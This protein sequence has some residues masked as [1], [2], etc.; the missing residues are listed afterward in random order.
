MTVYGP[1]GGLVGSTFNAN[2]ADAWLGLTITNAGTYTVVLQSYR[3][4]GD[5]GTYTLH[6]A[7]T[8]GAFIVPAGDEGGAMTSGGNYSGT[9][10]IGDLDLWSFSASAGDQVILRIGTIGVYPEMTVYG[11][12]GGLVGSTFNANYADAWLGLTIT[13]TGTYTVVLQSYRVT[14]DSGTY[15]LHFAET[16]GAFIVPVH[17]EGGPLANGVTHFATNSVGDLDMWSFVG[18]PGDSNILQIVGTS[19]YPQMDLYGPDGVLVKSVGNGALSSTLTYVVTNAG[20]YTVLVQSYYVNGDSGTY[21]LRYSRVP[22]DLIVPDTQVL[23]EGSTLNVSISAQDPDLPIKALTFAK[24]SAPPGVVLTLT[25][26]T[27]ATITWPTDETTGP[28]TNTIVVT[29]TDNVGGKNFTRTNSFIVIVNELNEPPVLT[30]PNQQ[31]IDE[32]TPLNVSASATDP[33]IPANP[34]T[35]SLVSPPTGMTIDPNTGAIA[36]TP[37]EAQGPVT[38]TVTVVVMDTNPPAV[39]TT[40]IS[41]TNSFV[42]V[43]REVNL[44]PQLTVPGNQTITELTPLNVSASATDPDIP[45]NPLTFSLVSPPTGMTIDPNTG[46]IAWTPTEAQGPGVYTVAVAVT[47]FNPSAGNAQ[48]LSVTN[49]FTVTVNESN[50]PPVLQPIADR[51][52]HYAVPLSIQAVVTDA[53]LPTN[54][55][56]FSLDSFPSN[57]TINA[58]SGLIS[59]TPVLAQLGT[60]TITVRVTDNGVPVKFDTTTF[61][62]LVT[63]NAPVLAISSLPGNLKQVIITGDVGLSYDLL[64]SSN[65][66]NWDLL[67]NFNLTTSPKAYVDPDSATILRRFYRLR[68]AP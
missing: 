43:V 57:M 14:G 4:T 53:D 65:L 34:L 10:S 37:T 29:V 22:P 56:T 41:V 61:K 52:S 12:D 33:D 50:S 3:V 13:N 45:A 68:L 36:W 35:F 23:N 20:M 18:T 7:E 31:V 46:A 49:S 16:H 5:S 2:Y 15:T 6:F 38:N 26:S 58:T 19:L 21:T 64:A 17:D 62:V 27:N 54:T 44:P 39:N 63:G 40:S 8:H 1:D 60:N 24:L 67:L 47:D 11:P 9:I 59:W 51:S 42:V 55:L 66:V 32:L 48:H 25:G 30:V 28:S